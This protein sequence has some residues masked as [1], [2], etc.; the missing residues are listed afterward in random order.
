VIQEQRSA[1]SRDQKRHLPLVVLFLMVVSP[2]SVVLQ[3]ALL[4]SSHNSP[5]RRTN[6]AFFGTKRVC[7]TLRATHPWRLELSCSCSGEL[8][9]VAHMN[10]IQKTNV[11]SVEHIAYAVLMP[12]LSPQLRAAIAHYIVAS[13]RVI[14]SPH[15]YS[16]ISSPHS[17]IATLAQRYRMLPLLIR[18]LP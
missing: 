17:Y 7:G 10:K 2:G 1:I 9:Q 4:R 15:S 6:H 3:F 12:T 13:T 16:C 5:P 18:I 11:R 8:V 14:R